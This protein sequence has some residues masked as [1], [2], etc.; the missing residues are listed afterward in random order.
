MMRLWP[1][2]NGGC[3]DCLFHAVSV[4]LWGCRDEH[5]VL[6]N[7]VATVLDHDRELLYDIWKREYAY[8]GEEEQASLC[9]TSSWYLLL[10]CNCYLLYSTPVMCTLLYS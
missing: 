5:K 7:M 9:C 1:L 6:Q 8:E 2:Q 4:A 10:F 3:G